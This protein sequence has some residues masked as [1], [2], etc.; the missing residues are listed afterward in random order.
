MRCSAWPPHLLLTYPQTRRFGSA[1]SPGDRSTRGAAAQQS[2]VLRLSRL[3]HSTP[4]PVAKDPIARPPKAKATPVGY[5]T[6]CELRPRRKLS[7]GSTTDC[8]SPTHGKW[9]SPSSGTKRAPVIRRARAEGNSQQI[10]LAWADCLRH[11]FDILHV[12]FGR[13]VRPVTIGKATPVTIVEH[14]RPVFGKSPEVPGYARCRTKPFQVAEKPGGYSSTGATAD[15]CV[16]GRCAIC[17][18]C[19]LDV[20]QGGTTRRR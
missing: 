15:H 17:T 4:G 1:D 5:S 13:E 11:G 2:G 19:V 16:C 20:E 10:H 9:A 7:I 12:V 14:H 18:H 6:A 3:G 8:Q